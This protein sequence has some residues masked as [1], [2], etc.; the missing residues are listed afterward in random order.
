MPSLEAL[1]D[2]SVNSCRRGSDDAPVDEEDE[3]T[4]SIV[5]EDTEESTDDDLDGDSRAARRLIPRG[6]AGANDDAADIEHETSSDRGEE[7]PTKGA[8][9]V[10]EDGDEDAEDDDDDDDDDDGEGGGDDEDEVD[11]EE[12]E[13]VTKVPKGRFFL[14]DDRH[15]KKGTPRHRKIWEDSRADKEWT[16]DK[17]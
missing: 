14:H 1:E 13:A 11:K 5:E 16:H 10:D 4:G 3:S 6:G 17:L 15:L 8:G 9:C 12:I 2:D 7:G